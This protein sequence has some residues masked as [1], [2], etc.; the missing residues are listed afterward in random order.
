MFTECL[1]SLSG[2]KLEQWSAFLHSA[3]L[4]PDLGVES[5]VLIWEDETL[6][7]C[8]SRQKNILKCIAV[9]P[10]HQGEGLTATLL[11]HLR[12]DAFSAGHKHL[13]LY[14]KP[15]N[16]FMFSSLF[17]YP[18][19]KTDSVLL[20]ENVRGGI[21][22]FLSTLPVKS[23]GGKIGA[24]VMHC[25]PF[26]HGHRYLIETAARECDHLYLF[27]LSEE[28]SIF[29]A[30]DRIEL[31][32]QG[33]A[34]LPN[35][36]VYPTGQYLIS[37]ATFPSYFLKDKGMVDDAH[38]KLDIAVFSRYFVPRFGITH[39]FVG[40]EPTCVVTNHYNEALKTYL[41]DAGV[42]VVEIPRLKTDNTPISAS[43]VRSLL[44]QGKPDELRKLVPP[45]TFQ[46]LQTH[47]FI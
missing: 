4:T 3:G 33:T 25:N 39:R 44:H 22:D 20:M 36:T 30:A 15:Q 1:G 10:A 32:R 35:V 45:T 37:S 6:I 38:C 46:Y 27:V 24:I 7:A 41:P 34:D 40:T 29:P 47:D 13:F 21:S 26:T 12:Q 42:E 5:T 16:Q 31:V 18:V 19:V 8:G 23:S 43:V 14:T 9:D 11:T 28:Q 17:F 2:A